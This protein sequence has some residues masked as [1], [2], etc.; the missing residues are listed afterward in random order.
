[1]LIYNEDSKNILNNINVLLQRMD[2]NLNTAKDKIIDP[3]KLCNIVDQNL[4]WAIERVIENVEGT[5]DTNRKDKITILIGS[6][7]IKAGENISFEILETF[8][9]IYIKQLPGR[10]NRKRK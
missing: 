10:V 9:P 7:V 4:N 5:K 3:I 1:M 8:S 2:E 6:Q